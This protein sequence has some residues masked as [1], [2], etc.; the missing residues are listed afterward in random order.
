MGNYMKK[1][2]LHCLSFAQAT[3][4]SK[5]I[6]LNGVYYTSS[7]AL[8]EQWFQHT[9]DVEDWIVPVYY[10]SR[11]LDFIYLSLDAK[12]LFL[13]YRIENTQEVSPQYLENYYSR[14]NVLKTQYRRKKK[15]KHVKVFGQ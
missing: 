11:N 1:K 3:V 8:K 13:A 14:L 12:G 15:R 4:T 9:S 5:G 2:Q 7:L 10:D 6:N